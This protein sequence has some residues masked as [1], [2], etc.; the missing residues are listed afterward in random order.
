MKATRT[1][2]ALPF[3][4]AGLAALLATIYEFG[5]ALFTMSLP[6]VVFGFAALVMSGILLAVGGALNPNKSTN[7]K[8]GPMG[9]K[10]IQA[11]IIP[12]DAGTPITTATIESSLKTLQGFV[13]GYIEA[14]GR[15][16]DWTAFANEE[17]KLDGQP[18]NQRATHALAFI[19]GHNPNDPLVGDVILV[20]TDKN[21]E[22]TSIPDSL[23]VKVREIA[24]EVTT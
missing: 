9:G 24:G 12:A 20:G 21:G 4:I 2:L 1:L 13:G 23:A 17:G 10:T 7:R 19:A 3:L 16:L 15:G 11:L 22:T 6:D 18:Y 8:T 14:V 5:K